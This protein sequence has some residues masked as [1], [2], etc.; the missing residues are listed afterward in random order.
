MCPDST[1]KKFSAINEARRCVAFA[2]LVVPY[3]IFVGYIESEPAWKRV[4]TK[5]EKAKL[6]EAG[7]RRTHR[8]VDGDCGKWD[9][10]GGG[11]NYFVIARRSS[12]NVIAFL[13]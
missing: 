11:G 3:L 13:S 12:S 9:E 8:A 10:C 4:A 1:E 2:L 5:A 7:R 6:G